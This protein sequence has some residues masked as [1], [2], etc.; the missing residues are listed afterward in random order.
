MVKSVNGLR[1]VNMAFRQPTRAN[2]I[3]FTQSKLNLTWATA[4]VSTTADITN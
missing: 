3:A 1:F 2:V 4:A